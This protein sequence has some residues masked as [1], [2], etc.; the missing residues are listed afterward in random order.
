MNGDKKKMLVL[1]V[2][3][4]L[5]VAVGAFSFLSGGN[6]SASAE[7]T[8]TKADAKTTAVDDTDPNAVKGE[9]DLKT[10]TD[11]T[12]NPDGTPKDGLLAMVPLAPR[13]PFTIPAQL[14]TR[15]KQEP[16]KPVPVANT[17]VPTTLGN[18]RPEGNRPFPPPMG[19]LPGGG[20]GGGVPMAVVPQYTVKGIIL[21]AKPLAV[22]QDSS[23]NQKLVSLGGSID[24]DTTVV[25]IEKG[26]VT[27]SYK[28]K[29][30]SLVIDEEAR[31][32]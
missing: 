16:V 31:N 18:N 27:V 5:L 14:D 21:G 20:I 4:L 10:E 7:L 9:G 12:K 32:D 28:G 23:G 25:A 29:R 19:E 15:P 11:P 6:S 26:K 30:Q 22:F 17:Q 8:T 2:L 1:G 24:G 3:A 13:D